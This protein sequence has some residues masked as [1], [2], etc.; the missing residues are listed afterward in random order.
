MRERDQF[1][2]GVKTRLD[3][4]TSEI[5]RLESRSHEVGADAQLEYREQL[6]LLKER[7]KEVAAQ[8]DTLRNT[9]DDAWQSLKSR[10]ELAWTAMDD[11]LKSAMAR[12]R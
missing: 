7:R 9:S 8:V 6:E 5:H 11:A 4:C 12:L 10:T 1:I 2:E 3:H